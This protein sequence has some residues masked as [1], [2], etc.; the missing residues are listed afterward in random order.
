MRKYRY[1]I[2]LA[3]I[4]FYNNWLLGLILNFHASLAG[5]TTSELGA[6]DQPWHVLF[7]ALDVIAG[8]LFI[9]S[10]GFIARLGTSSKARLLLL[11]GLITLGI[12]TIIESALIPLDC[13]SAVEKICVQQETL[14][15]VSWQHNFHIME[16]VISYAVTTFVPLTLLVTL[17]ERPGTYRVRQWSLMLLG[18]MIIWAIETAVRFSHQA[19]SYGY[20]QRIFIIVFSIWFWV[21]AR[22][23][24]QIYPALS[25]G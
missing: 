13:S 18:F 22:L 16:S 10:A 25:S 4:V 12:S 21:A 14:G 3:A 20:E 24:R 6:G 5:A 7:R 11:V 9:I 19:V 1:Q 8:F 2:A 15:L 23:A 17:R